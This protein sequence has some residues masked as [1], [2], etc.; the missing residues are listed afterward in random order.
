MLDGG[1]LDAGVLYA[2]MTTN[3]SEQRLLE[4]D[5]EADGVRWSLFGEECVLRE[6][7]FRTSGSRQGTV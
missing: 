6:L 5:T 2:T 4:G 7:G 1:V 3:R